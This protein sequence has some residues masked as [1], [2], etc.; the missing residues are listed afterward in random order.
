MAQGFS[1]NL[2][3]D[4]IRPCFYN[5]LL[6]DN[7]NPLK[8][9]IAK[10]T[11]ILYFL[12]RGNSKWLWEMEQKIEGF[13]HSFFCPIAG[14]LLP[15]STFSR[16][17]ICI[18]PYPLF[19][20]RFSCSFLRPPGSLQGASETCPPLHQFHDLIVLKELDM[21]LNKKAG[22]KRNIYLYNLSSLAKNAKEVALSH[23]VSHF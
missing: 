16:F 3:M 7:Q 23:T 2:V 12:N 6:K 20:G 17:L 10:K 9:K 13:I 11:G 14:I 4:V 19:P 21:F 15:G 1:H 18:T 22:E 8:F 5:E